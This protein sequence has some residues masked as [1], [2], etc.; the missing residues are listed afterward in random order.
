MKRLAVSNR[1]DG[2]LA[3]GDSFRRYGPLE[4]HETRKAQV[5]GT[6]LDRLRARRQMLREMTPE[7]ALVTIHFYQRLNLFEALAL[8]QKEGKLIVP[9]DVHDKISTETKDPEEQGSLGDRNRRLRDEKY[10]RQNYP[11]WAGTLVIYEKPDTLFGESIGYQGLVFQ[12]KQ[13]ILAFGQVL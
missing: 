1:S 7:Q 3:I 5:T 10:L 11:V 12:V 6:E 8:A 13:I 9:N 2:R 4:S